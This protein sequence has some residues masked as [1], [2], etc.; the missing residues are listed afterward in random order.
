[1]KS[2]TS[3]SFKKKESKVDGLEA[4]NRR[5]IE[6]F[7]KGGD[8]KREQQGRRSLDCTEEH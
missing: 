5:S 6:A 7:I 2:H 4:D 3:K 1:M 8:E